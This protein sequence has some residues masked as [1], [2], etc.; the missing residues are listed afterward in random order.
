MQNRDAPAYQEYAAQMMAKIDYR[1]LSLTERGLLY[2]MKL[3]CWVND[4]LPAELDRL[5]RVLGFSCDEVKNALPALMP[6]FAIVENFIV[7]PELE[8]YKLHLFSR[9]QRMSEG[10][11]KSAQKRKGKSLETT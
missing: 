3:E 9:R 2:S 1:T 6:F 10:G 8:N 7:S 5:A 4:K 11:K